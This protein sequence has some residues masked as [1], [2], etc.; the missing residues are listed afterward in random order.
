MSLP[1]I[2][3][4]Q[5]SNAFIDNWL[6]KCTP[7][8]TKCFL[9]IARLTIG[10]HKE[11]ADISLS[12]LERRTGMSRHT[13]YDATEKLAEKGLISKHIG[14]VMT[15]YTID[16]DAVESV[17]NSVDNSLS[18]AEFTPA[19]DSGSAKFAPKN[20]VTSAEFAP[21]KP[22]ASAKTAHIKE[23]GVKKERKKTYS[24][25]VVK[26]FRDLGADYYHDGREAKAASDLSDRYLSDPEAYSNMV[27]TLKRLHRDDK[28]Y[29]RMPFSPSTLNTMWNSIAEIAK[30]TAAKKKPAQEEARM[31]NGMTV[32]E[33]NAQVE[34]E[35]RAKAME[36]RQ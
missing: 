23:K 25:E 28:F 24:A 33:Y 29:K 16:Y 34:A 4:T 6:M 27:E 18:S 21:E 13:V 2:N 32:A 20:I 7:A 17:E 12:E 15:S 22:F 35:E 10:W 9:V 1:K 5:V 8:E 14:K 31:A 3:H 36:V 19:E 26:V 30:E 11:T